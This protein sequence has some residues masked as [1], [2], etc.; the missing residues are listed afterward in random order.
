MCMLTSDVCVCTMMQEFEGIEPCVIC[1]STL[2]PRDMSLPTLVCKTCKNRFHPSCLY[3]WFQ[4]SHK[5]LCPLCQQ[6]W[7]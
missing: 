5:H 4:T 2:H 3:K 6:A 1:Y 7:G